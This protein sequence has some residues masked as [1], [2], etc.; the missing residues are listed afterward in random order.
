M[1][2]SMIAVSAD[3]IGAIVV[4]LIAVRAW[5]EMQQLSTLNTDAPI[6]DTNFQ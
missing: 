5:P 2:G 6:H 1:F 3:G 4:V